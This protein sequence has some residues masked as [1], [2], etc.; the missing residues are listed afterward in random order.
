MEVIQGIDAPLPG[1]RPLAVVPPL[2]PYVRP[3]QVEADGIRKRLNLFAQRAL[4]HVALSDEQAARINDTALLAQAVSAGVIG[5]LELAIESST[6][7]TPGT[8]GDGGVAGPPIT[9]IT[10]RFMLM[11]GHAIAA[12]GL[13]VELAYPLRFDPDDI[14]VHGE[15]L[16]HW[17]PEG[18]ALHTRIANGDEIRLG[19]LMKPDVDHRQPLDFLPHAMVLVAQPV[20]VAIREA[21][22]E[23]SVCENATDAVD[24]PDI[25][26]EDGFRLVWV[27]WPK[28]RALAPWTA[29]GTAMDTRFR[30]R[31]AYTIFDDERHP[32]EL[33]GIRSVRRMTESRAPD[34][35]PPPRRRGEAPPPPLQQ[36]WPWEEIGVPLALV[37]FDNAFRPAFADRAAVVRQGG[38]P[39]NRTRLL[40]MAG[41]DALWQA[42]VAQMLEQVAELPPGERDA[43]QLVTHFERLPP[44]GVLPLD[45]M[46]FEKKRQS[47]FPA[48]YEV[49]VQPV[50]LDMVD[51]L[52]AES[53]PLASLNL[54]AT[55]QVQVLVPVPSRFYEPDLL[56]LDERIHPLFDLEIS[57]LEDER[58]RLLQ[59]RDALRRRID[60]LTKAASGVL[61]RYAEDDP[62]ALPDENGALDAMASA[63]VRDVQV[64]AGNTA[65]WH[66]FQG[67]QA[68][69]P[70]TPGDA[71]MVFVRFN[72]PVASLSVRTRVMAMADGRLTLQPAGFYWGAK[73]VEQGL[74][75]VNA[76]A[77]PT[78]DN[79]QVPTNTWLRLLAP[80]TL[81]DRNA[82]GQGIANPIANVSVDTLEFGVLTA[83]TGAG[84]TWG[85]CGTL[86]GGLES[87]WV[88]DA[89][90]PGSIPSTNSGPFTWSRDDGGVTEAENNS[91]GVSVDGIKGTFNVGELATLAAT[92]EGAAGGLKREIGEDW[93]R[94]SGETLPAIAPPLIEQGLAALIVRLDQRI[95]AADDHVEVGFLR[96]RTDIYR[97]RNGVL[98]TAM[99]G[100]LLTSPAAADLVQQSESPVLTDKVFADYFD[101]A[102]GLNVPPRTP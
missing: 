70:L 63:R 76:G 58:L 94:S 36:P 26:W 90:P 99:A 101:R 14:A 21:S 56:N 9:T 92:F 102:K 87:Y 74:L 89:F 65:H 91:W 13:D 35:P 80:V 5:G 22:E 32:L 68:K 52:M 53:A 37:G 93:S 29:D 73:P 85:Y 31:L 71:L 8:A 47:F 12:N 75:M 15:T 83:D 67:A 57:R 86:N 42:R 64:V 45:A 59:R 72:A 33:D 79:G 69:L 4:T 95:A 84:I 25:A 66:G 98:G 55:D 7:V 77:L 48:T 44:A 82:A 62:N 10:T 51:A 40:R 19:E 78:D 88:A 18:D 38:G 50:P 39:H 20:T 1:E 17:V 54:S 97:L 24:S 3:E 100:R 27:P 2:A 96:A 23:L 16:G 41:D 49:Q 30:N 46:D 34:D 60:L 43:P 11:P 6:T 61:P 81:L 28:E